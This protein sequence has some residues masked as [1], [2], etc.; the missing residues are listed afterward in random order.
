MNL[1]LRAHENPSDPV[2]SVIIMVIIALL[3]TTYYI[4][5]L[6][7]LASGEIEEDT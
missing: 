4:Y 3:G 5:Y 6:M 7:N 2:W 1:I